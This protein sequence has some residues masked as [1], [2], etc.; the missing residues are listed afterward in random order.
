MQNTGGI[1]RIAE[2][3]GLSETEVASLLQSRRGSSTNAIG[4]LGTAT[5]VFTRRV[6]LERI[7]EVVRR[8][9]PMLDGR[10]LL[11][12]AVAGDYV[13]VLRG[14]ETMFDLSRVAP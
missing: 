8:P 2:I 14:I 12:L 6:R 1:H 7:P 5:E 11:E 3:W 13:G 10:S 9:A 4:A